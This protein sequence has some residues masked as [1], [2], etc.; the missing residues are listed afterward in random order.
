MDRS[1]GAVAVPWARGSRRLTALAAAGVAVVVLGTSACSGSSLAG[2][3]S[4]GPGEV[5]KIGF[6]SDQSGPQKEIGGDQLHGFQLYLK[7]HHNK[8]G[9]HK[10]KLVNQDETA[11]TGKAL[12]AAKKLINKDHVVAIAGLTQAATVNA[13]QPL[14]TKSK[15]PLV[16][17]LGRPSSLKDSSYVWAT[18]FMS[19]AFGRSMAGYVSKHEK[20]A[21]VYAIGPDQQGG[22]DHVGGFAKEYKK[23]GGKIANDKNKPTYTPWGNWN[24]DYQPYLSKIKNSDAKA[25][26]AFF[27]GLDAISFVKQ[28]KQFGLAGQIPLYASGAL[29][30]G[31][32]LSAEGKSAIGI[33]NSMCYSPDLD[34]AANRKFVSAYQKAYGGLP[35]TY[36]MTSYDSAYVLDKAIKAA[37]SDVTGESVNKQINK[38]GQ[39][40][41]PR[42]TWQF[43]SG[44]TPLQKWYLRD[45]EKDG[46]SLANVSVR[47]L[48]MFG[49][50]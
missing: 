46:N 22:Y 28:Y 15:T 29:T 48:G 31:S 16:G 5:L 41:S 2:S 9:G 8:L 45:V 24:H 34:N 38:L 12:V 1:L 11:D 19:T 10:V 26:F 33:K 50:K 27:F 36:V 30:E 40:D 18:S 3:D 20:N 14:A 49:T 6:I 43:D 21:P 44:H 25:V 32:L 47:D 35:T 13:I 17:S 7:M 42:G 23:D 37:G 39:I 4:S